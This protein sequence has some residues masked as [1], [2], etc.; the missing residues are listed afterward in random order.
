MTNYLSPSALCAAL[1]LRDLT[2]PTQG[3]HAMQTLLNAVLHRLSELWGAEPRCVVGFRGIL[4][5][6]RRL[7]V[8]R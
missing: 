3:P 5:V 7:G 1:N 2:D 4:D 8:R 6:T